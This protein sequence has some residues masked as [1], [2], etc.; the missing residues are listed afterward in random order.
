[1]QA[2]VYE[3]DRYETKREI[4]RERER[5][6]TPKS[7]DLHDQIHVQGARRQVLHLDEVRHEPKL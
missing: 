3:A 5:K 4:E 1:M 7:A 2:A 6:K